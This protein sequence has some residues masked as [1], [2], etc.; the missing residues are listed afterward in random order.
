MIGLSIEKIKK[1][2]EELKRTGARELEKEEVSQKEETRI[3]R[4]DLSDLTQERLKLEKILQEIN[5][6][7]GR[8][9]QRIGLIKTLER[10]KKEIE[11]TSN[12]SEEAKKKLDN[13]RGHI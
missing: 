7:K 10:G 12:F 2:A 9:C 1:V 11:R 4:D 3:V 6:L 5:N 8:I 13:L